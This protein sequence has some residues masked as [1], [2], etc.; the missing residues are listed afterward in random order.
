MEN[1]I[2]TM[3]VYDPVH[4]M[5]S[6]SFKKIIPAGGKE[7]C[8]FSNTDCNPSGRRD[9]LIYFHGWLSFKGLYREGHLK[10]FKCDAGG[11]LNIYGTSEEDARAVCYYSDGHVVN[12]AIIGDV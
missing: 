10:S 4:D 2:G 8:H 7:C 1:S 6:Y 12:Q 5:F 11:A 9:M 3:D